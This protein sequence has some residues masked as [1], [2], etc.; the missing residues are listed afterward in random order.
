MKK[1]YC[2]EFLTWSGLPGTRGNHMQPGGR[3][4]SHHKNQFSMTGVGLSNNFP[5]RDMEMGGAQTVPFGEEE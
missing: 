3:A 1:I 4:F 5:K 2:P